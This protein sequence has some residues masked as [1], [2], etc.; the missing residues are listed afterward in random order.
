MRVFKG[1][2]V[3]FFVAFLAV[4][5]GITC[6]LLRNYVSLRKNKKAPKITVAAV[7]TARWMD[8]AGGLP[9][10]ILGGK[11][12]EKEAESSGC[13]ASFQTADGEQLVFPVTLEEYG[14]LRDG[15]SG[16]LT[17]QGTWFQG[18]EQKTDI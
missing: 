15:A 9:P 12:K 16:Q 14:A 7:L 17:Y 10:S 11:S 6:I 4:L 5:A 2:G 1:M 13:Y 3:F 8:S 18:F